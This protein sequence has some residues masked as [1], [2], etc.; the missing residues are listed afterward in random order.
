MRGRRL[1]VNSK[2]ERYYVERKC[3]WSPPLHKRIKIVRR[4]FPVAYEVYVS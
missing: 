1:V 3:G 2:E 4:E